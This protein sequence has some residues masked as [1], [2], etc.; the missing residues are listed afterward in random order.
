[1]TTLGLVTAR[2][3]SKSV[4]RKNVALVAN[5]PLIAWTIDAAREAR[6]LDRV[7]VST[8]DPEIAA[9]AERCG[10]EVPFLRPQELALDDTPHVAVVEHALW[11]LGQHEGYEPDWV[12]TLQPTSPLRTGEDIDGAIALAHERQPDAVAGVSPSSQHP[13]LAKR[14]R[15]DGT[16]E[17]FI[18]C[19][20]AYRRRQALP[21][22]YAL[23]GA[24]FLN[25]TVAL[26]AQRTMFPARTIA[27]VMPPSRSLDV[28]EPWDLEHAG[29]LLAARAAV[30]R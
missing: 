22:A 13:L 6:R 12:F 24:V 27:Y 14:M 26:L 19:D 18:P 15:E 30:R 7:I 1:M 17:D 16:L 23:N 11:W 2:G 5:R 4:P 21:A 20:L 9:V 8:D 28:D 25:R 3:G 29:L 10:A